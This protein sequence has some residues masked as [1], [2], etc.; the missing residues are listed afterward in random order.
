MEQITKVDQEP[1]V[2]P[3]PEAMISVAE[4]S[5]ILGVAPTTLYDWAR[6]AK[7]PHYKI[8]ERVRFRA[9]E[10]ETWVSGLRVEASA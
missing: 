8:G 1:V 10:L 7:V 6:A 3:M 9:S 5:R 2:A 4:A